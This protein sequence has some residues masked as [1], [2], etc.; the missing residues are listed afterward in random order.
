MYEE[1][2]GRLLDLKQLGSQEQEWLTRRFRQEFDRYLR[3]DTTEQATAADS[4]ADLPPTA[5]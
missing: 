3:H 2:N 4:P 5:H 1:E